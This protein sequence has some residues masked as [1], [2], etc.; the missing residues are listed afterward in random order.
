MQARFRV[1][2]N[3]ENSTIISYYIRQLQLYY[4][5]YIPYAFELL[6]RSKDTLSV[7]PCFMD[8]HLIQTPHYYVKFALSLGKEIPYIFS[9]FNLLNIDTLLIQ[10]VYAFYGPSVTGFDCAKKYDLELN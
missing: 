5:Y 3:L 4:H 7:K 9:K 1:V 6:H 10:V 8:T 2:L